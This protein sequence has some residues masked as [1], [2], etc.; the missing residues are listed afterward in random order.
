MLYAYSDGPRSAKDAVK[1]MEVRKILRSIDWCEVR[2]TER[3]TNIGLGRSILAGVTEVL[4]KHDAI[5]VFEDDLICVHGT[6]DYLCSALEHYRDD[7]RVMSV[8]GWTHPIVTPNDI[9]DEPY[10][11]GRA[12]CLAWGTWARAWQ[13]ME[14]DAKTLMKKCKA[15]GIDIYKYGSDLVDMARM[16]LRQKPLGC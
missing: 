11:D 12:E 15:E 14:T 4:C 9:R 3:E 8:T 16:E 7:T 5:I 1:V 10:F 2:L 6:Y 13:G